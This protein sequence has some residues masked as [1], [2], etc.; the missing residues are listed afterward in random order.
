[1]LAKDLIT[2]S[3]LPLRT[4]T[5]GEDALHIMRDAVVRHLPIVNNTQFL[6]LISEDDIL[7]GNIEDPIGSY[8]LA[9]HKPYVNADDHLVEVL[10]IMGQGRLTVIPV[11]NDKGD[12]LGLITQD[13][14]LA[15]LASATSLAEN[16]SILIIEVNRRDFTP[17]EIGRIIE[18][19]NGIILLMYLSSEPQAE[20]MEVTIKLHAPSVSRIVA[21]LERY[22][23]KVKASYQESDYTES[24]K[25]NYESLLNYLNV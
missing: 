9:A 1:M 10:R 8:E 20:V 25:E 22:K 4:S 16:G 12:Y 24:L 3:I 11:L 2:E 13:D 19:E 5:T 6:G 23:Y 15:H 14:L 18:G 21:S 17:G 7:A